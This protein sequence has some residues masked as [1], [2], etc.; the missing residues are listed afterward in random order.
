[1]PPEL[2]QTQPALEQ[3]CVASQA[4]YCVP[5]GHCVARTHVLIWT[6]QTAAPSACEQLPVLAHAAPM[7]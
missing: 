2:Q 5:V 3:G 1:M 6:Q 4:T 7:G